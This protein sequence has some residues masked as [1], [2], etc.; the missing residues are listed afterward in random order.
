MIFITNCIIPIIIYAIIFILLSEAVTI[1]LYYIEPDIIRYIPWMYVVIIIMV[2]IASILFS[3]L[4]EQI[5][6]SYV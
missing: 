6:L 4:G 3:L 1:C 5:Y 2:A